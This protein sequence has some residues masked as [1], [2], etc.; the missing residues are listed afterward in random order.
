MVKINNARLRFFT[1]KEAKD[2][3]AELE[4]VNPQLCD[5]TML[6]L[7]TGLRATKIFKLK[8]QDVDA[9]AH[10]LYIIEKGG[11]LAPV[12]IPEDMIAMRHTKER[13]WY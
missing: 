8:G 10:I 13:L 9:H 6:S 5:M 11:K 7:R 1:P 12:R 3:L 2:L 4:T